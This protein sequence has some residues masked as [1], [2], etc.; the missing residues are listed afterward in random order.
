MRQHKED[1]AVSSAALDASARQVAQLQ[2]ANK[3]LRERM[4]QVRQLVALT[5]SH[6]DDVDKK[7]VE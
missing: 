5:F 4:Q 7:L 2:E 1:E 6:E 3:R